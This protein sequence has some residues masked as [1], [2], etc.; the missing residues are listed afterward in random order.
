MDTGPGTAGDAGLTPAA[1]PGGRKLSVVI[2]VALTVLALDVTTK[3][4]VV[5][6]LASRPPIRLLDGFLTL[7]LLRNSGAAF[8]IGTSMTIVFTV[9]AAAVIF[10]ILRA[11]RKLRSL[12]W[13]ITLGLLL[14]GATGNLSDRIFRSP[15]LFRGD[16]VDWIQLPHWPVFNLADSAIVCGGAL[17]VLLALR[18]VRLDG[19]REGHPEDDLNARAEPRTTQTAPA[20]QPSRATEASA[21]SQ[22]SRVTEATAVSQPSRVT[23][24][25]AVSQ[26]SRVTEASSTA[27]ASP[28]TEVGPATEAGGVA[29]GSSVT[30]VGPATETGAVAGGSS[31]TE[32]G[33]ATETGPATQIAHAAEVAPT[34]EVPNN[35]EVPKQSKNA[36]AAQTTPVTSMTQASEAEDDSAGSALSACSRRSGRRAARRRSGPDVRVVQVTGCRTDQRGDGAGRWP[37]R[38]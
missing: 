10:Y 13:A 25:T 18:G 34:I 22:P 17:A 38:G 27:Q 7:L 35:A 26:P 30:E 29:G 16:V 11:A 3:V 20:S 1:A 9:I 15:G 21:V 32:V 24:A 28:V 2:G 23:E 37:P 6:A 33:P 36:A 5:R 8:S 12:A 31:V 14:G 4:I 19:T